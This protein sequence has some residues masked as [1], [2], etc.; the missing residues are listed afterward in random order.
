M[1]RISTILI[2]LAAMFA[3]T[4]CAATPTPGG[5]AAV[6]S[7]DDPRL[8]DQWYGVLATT[9]SSPEGDKLTVRLFIDN[10][11]VKVA[12]L[13]EKGIW[14]E[15]M[16]GL[17]RISRRGGNAVIQATNSNVSEGTSWIQ[18]KGWY[19]TWVFAVTRQSEDKLQAEFIRVV[20]NVGF[21][22]S[23]ADA[24]FSYSGTGMLSRVKSR[25]PAQAGDAIHAVTDVIAEESGNYEWQGKSLSPEQLKSA[26]LA[27]SKINPIGNVRLHEGDT[28]LNMQRKLDFAL[29][30][31]AAGGKAFVE[32]GNKFVA[33]TFAD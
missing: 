28:S 3:L 7:S 17:F 12:I 15:V 8:N 32:D 31:R 9:K 24:A 6:S 30:V 4:G 1:N 27:Q 13:D 23:Q 29:I 11:E 19:E 22:A 21:P 26:L 10:S 5:R 16:A 33:M 14:Q 25:T 2:A 18:A 20:K